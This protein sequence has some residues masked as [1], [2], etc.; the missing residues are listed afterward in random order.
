MSERVHETVASG[1]VPG[2]SDDFVV[3]P[4]LVSEVMP[5]LDLGL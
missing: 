2:H 5:Y 3:T 4:M 1:V